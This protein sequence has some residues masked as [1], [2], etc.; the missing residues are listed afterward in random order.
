MRRAIFYGISSQMGQ[1][2]AGVSTESCV[3]GLVLIV[4][5]EHV[6]LLSIR[7]QAK[8]SD[9]FPG[10]HCS[11][12][13]HHDYSHWDHLYINSSSILPRQRI[14]LGALPFYGLYKKKVEPA[15]GQL[16]SL[17][18]RHFANFAMVLMI[19]IRILDCTIWDQYR[20]ECDLGWYRSSI[21]V[22][23]IYQ[24]EKGSL[25]CKLRKEGKKWK[26]GKSLT[27]RPRRWLFQCAHGLCYQAQQSSS[28][29]WAAMLLSWPLSAVSWSAT[30]FS[31][32]GVM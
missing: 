10:R 8:R 29:S 1:I 14:T 12:F 30:T 7:D 24:L 20:W 22:P 32:E 9:H 31:Y 5:L 23:E 2:V 27:L 28:A 19:S 18:V 16:F 15:L 17:H 6:R 13:G 21:N 11:S 25:Y 4:D 3:R 26:D